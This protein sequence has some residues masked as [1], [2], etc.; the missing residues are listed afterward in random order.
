MQ[1][2]AEVLAQMA[3]D[4]QMLA[5]RLAFFHAEPAAIT[6][7]DRFGQVWDR[8]QTLKALEVVMREIEYLEAN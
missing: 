5:D 3:Q 4:E 1:T 2:K 7:T 8:S 6:V